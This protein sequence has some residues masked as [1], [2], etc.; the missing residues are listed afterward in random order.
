MRLQ[1]RLEFEKEKGE[2]NYK[3][4][5]KKTKYIQQAI[6]KNWYINDFGVRK[7]TN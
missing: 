7:E 4:K 1:L 2:E 6:K 3:N 5:N